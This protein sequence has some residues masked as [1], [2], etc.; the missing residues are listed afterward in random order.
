MSIPETISFDK[1]GAVEPRGWLYR[2]RHH[3][4][5]LFLTLVILLVAVLSFG[6]GRLTSGGKSEPIKIEYDAS[7]ATP[8]ASLPVALP[9]NGGVVASKSGSKYHYPSC[10]GAKQ[11]KEANKITFPSPQAAEA[12]G[13][14][15]AA[16][17]QSR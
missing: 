16:N 2:A 4:H 5:R 11:I 8:V 10:P 12:A 1:D 15:L 3:V 9:Q 14:T 6:I 7:L 17:C 13:Y